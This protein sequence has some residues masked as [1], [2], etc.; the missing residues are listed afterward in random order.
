MRVGL[1]IAAILQKLYPKEFDSSKLIGLVGNADTVQQLQAG[2]APEKIVL[3]WSSS[4][5][6]FEQARKKYFL[7]K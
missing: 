2:T 3:S 6:D 7:Y 4:L 1:E 5:N